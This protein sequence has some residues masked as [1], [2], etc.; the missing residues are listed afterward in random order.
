MTTDIATGNYLARLRDEAGLKQR[1]LA[2]RITWSATLLSRV[3]SGERAVSPDELERILAAIDT[4]EAQAFQKTI[5]RTWKCL[6]KPPLGHPNESLL[7]EAELVLREIESL[8][9]KPDIRN[10]SASLLGKLK[11]E[12]LRVSRLVAGTE[13]SLA[14]VGDIGV[15]KSTAI[16][17]VSGLEVHDG[18][19]GAPTPVLEAGGGGVTI[20]EVHLVSGP[21]YG[22]M[23]EPMGEQQ[24]ESEVRELASLMKEPPAPAD[25]GTGDA[26][27]GTSRELERAIRNMSGLTKQRRT[28]KGPAGKTVRR[29]IDPVKTLAEESANTATLT[30]EIVARMNLDS[31]TRRELWY[32][33]QT[34][35]KDALGWLKENFELLNNGRH[36]DFSIPRRVEI[37]VPDPILGEVSSSIRLVDTKGIDRTAERAD[38]ES[39]F[40]DPNTVVVMCSNFPAIPSHSIQQLLERVR[41]DGFVNMETKGIVLGLSRHDEALAVKDDEGFVAES[42][43]EGYELKYDEAQT[44]LQ[45]MG[46]SDLRVEFF[47]AM[48]DSPDNFRK[49]LVDLTHGLMRQ[50]R[51]EL[52][53]VLNDAGSLVDNFEQEQVLEVQRTA[54][55]HLQTWIENNRTLDFSSLLGPERSLIIAMNAAHPSSVRA[56]VRREGE[57]YNLDYPHQLSYGA[58]RTAQRVTKAKIEGFR[59]VVDNLLQNDDLDE[60]S[61]LLRHARRIVDAGADS[62]L[63]RCELLGR[64]IHSRRM[65]RSP[66]LWRESDREWGRGPGYRDRVVTHHKD[67]FDGDEQDF[68][69]LVQHLIQKEWEGSLNSLAEILEIT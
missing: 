47:N 28:E 9:E 31:R 10:S 58:K 25:D 41:D 61:G 33:P 53:A 63:K 32:S 56:S 2:D 19:K 45:S 66:D 30:I 67:W 54:A 42:V 13:Y 51:S 65:K 64:R 16:C 48:S 50:H 23:V 18:K 44:A 8:L 52:Q 14:L 15:G 68:R 26:A 20:C 34:S 40:S 21:E 57:W 12:L 60:A 29:V 69:E 36:P 1:E 38:L 37:V 35:N 46:L 11:D 39:L 4:E 62:L 7:W 24:I 22:L 43:E 55:R 6:P 49:L 27:F 59:A 5:R 17:R 3:E